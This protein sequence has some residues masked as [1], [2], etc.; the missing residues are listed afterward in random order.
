[1]LLLHGVYRPDALQQLPDLG[2]FGGVGEAVALV[3]IR[4]RSQ[5]LLQRAQRQ[6][7]GVLRD[8][9]HNG[10]SGGGQETA[11]GDFVVGEGGCIALRRV[12]PNARLQVPICLV[13]HLNHVISPFSASGG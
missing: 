12:L 8:I 11:P 2:S 13:D 10:L 3:P 6:L 9:A 1:M 7:V 4:Q 5:A